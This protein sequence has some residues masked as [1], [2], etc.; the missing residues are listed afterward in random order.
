MK[1]RQAAV[2]AAGGGARARHQQ[3]NL[4]KLR[5]LHTQAEA[6]RCYKFSLS[7]VREARQLFD[8]TTDTSG[9]AVY[10]CRRARR[11]SKR[12]RV[13]SRGTSFRSIC[14]SSMPQKQQQS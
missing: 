8:V 9:M 6:R 2:A 10:V 4:Q 13:C 5:V 7:D 14:M 3:V 12:A 1:T 11:R